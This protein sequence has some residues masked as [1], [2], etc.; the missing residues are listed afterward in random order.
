[1][2]VLPER[3]VTQEGTRGVPA[4]VRFRFA[5]GQLRDRRAFPLIL[6]FSLGEKERGATAPVVL[7]G[8]LQAQLWAG[9]ARGGWR[10]GGCGEPWCR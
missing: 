6:T 9:G 1:M 7:A 8:R 5:P 4:F 10:T 3:E 2:R